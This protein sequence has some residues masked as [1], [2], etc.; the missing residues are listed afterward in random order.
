MLL[1]ISIVLRR[2]DAKDGKASGQLCFAGDFYAQFTRIRV[3]L[4]N[5][6]F[7]KFGI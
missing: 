7:P 4:S 1:P 2:K 6:S 5:K 3:M